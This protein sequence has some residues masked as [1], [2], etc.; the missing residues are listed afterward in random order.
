MFSRI[1]VNL[2]VQAQT[3]TSPFIA[4]PLTYRIPLPGPLSNVPVL[5]P[6]CHCRVQ[7]LFHDRCRPHRWAGLPSAA[8]TPAVPRPR[9][10]LR[11]QPR[12]DSSCPA[13]LLGRTSPPAPRASAACRARPGVAGEHPCLIL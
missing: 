13:G 2:D 10:L 7:T 6:H 8:R 12:D 5:P 1:S 4:P 3:W 11:P 9:P